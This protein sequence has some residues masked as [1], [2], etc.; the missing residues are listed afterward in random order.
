L[1]GIIEATAAVVVNGGLSVI[2]G[3]AT[4][5]SASPSPPSSTFKRTFSD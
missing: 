2:I 3:G 5:P 1:S 4:V